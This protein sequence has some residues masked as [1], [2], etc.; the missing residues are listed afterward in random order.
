M[1]V[2]DLIP[3]KIFTT[4]KDAQ[5]EDEIMQ[6]TG[7]GKTWVRQFIRTSIEDGR[8]LEVWKRVPNKKPFKVYVTKKK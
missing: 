1:K 4:D 2:S 8:I 3:K 6:E 7:M 5:S